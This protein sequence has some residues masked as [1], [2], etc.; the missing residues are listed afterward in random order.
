MPEKEQALLRLGWVSGPSHWSSALLVPEHRSGEEVLRLATELEARFP[1][2][3]LVLARVAEA[4]FSPDVDRRTDAERVLRRALALDP[5]YRYVLTLLVDVLADRPAELLEI[6][7]RAVATRR[8]AANLAILAQVELTAGSR[9]AARE[10]AREALR[11]DGAQNSLVVWNACQPLDDLAGR[12]ACVDAWRSL[13]DAGPN[14]HE[15]DFA[16]LRLV[17]ALAIEGRRGEAL[18]LANSVPEFR[19]GDPFQLALVLSIGLPRTEA[20]ESRAVSRL[21]AN[22]VLRR[23]MVAAY[24]G[25][26]EAE[27]ISAALGPRERNDFEEQL[28]A[29][30]RL[31][32]LG[33][34]AE[35]AEIQRKNRDWAHEHGETG[36]AC[37]HAYL[38][39]ELLLAAG[40]IEEAASI[41]PRLPPRGSAVL[42]DRA[43]NGTRLALVRARAMA[44]LGRSA[45]AVRELDGLLSFWK[46]ADPDLPLLVEAKAMRAQLAKGAGTR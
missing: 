27:R 26:E 21:M 31:T 7:Q 41:E 11:L 18:R 16:R 6:A 42:L 1:D 36:P 40:R 4:Y 14:E 33:R 3:K 43:L 38:L 39:A 35:A 12:P 23:Y 45:D 32:A 2:D 28:Y 5:G 9:E 29:P 34:Y 24:G 22:A 20:A 30:L 10:A 8:S 25:A 13:L 17:E 19:R 46:D 44:Q 37:W 15:R